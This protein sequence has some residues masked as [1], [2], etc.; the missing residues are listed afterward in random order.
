MRSVILFGAGA[1]YGAGDIIPNKP[2]LGAEL[3]SE[4]SKNFP[5]SWGVLPQDAK[6]EFEVNFERGM[7]VI[8]DK[9]SGAVVELMRHMALYF[10]QFRAKKPGS[11]A[12]ASL[13]R[14]IQQRKLNGKVIVATLN[15][16]CLLELEFSH[17]GVEFSYSLEEVPQG[18]IK[19]LKPHGSCNFIPEGIS[20]PIGSIQI[21][22]GAAID[23]PVRVNGNM[24]EVIKHVLTQALPPIMCLYL[25]GKP[26]QV[27]TGTVKAIQKNLQDEIS[28]AKVVV[29]VG[30]HPNP[31]DTHIWDSIASCQGD[32][33]YIGTSSEVFVHW[34]KEYRPQ[35]RSIFLAESFE[36]GVVQIADFIERSENVS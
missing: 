3:Y 27:A 12:Y 2:P 35:G 28:E 18:T 32:V 20:G 16:E 15:Y 10:A 17:A 19:V 26:T 5:K 21:E 23:M 6:D 29:V 22:R 36:S 24:N 25:E 7:G 31:E 13:A 33:G 8:W 34:A 4:L 14:E 1:S 9:Y 11:T 30:V